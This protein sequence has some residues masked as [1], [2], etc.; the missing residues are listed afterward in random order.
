M[1][2]CPS[3]GWERSA[4]GLCPDCLYS[5]NPA[6]GSDVFGVPLRIACTIIA[7]T[8][9]QVVTLQIIAKQRG[10]RYAL[11]TAHGWQSPADWR[12]R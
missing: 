10:V 8:P 4:S 9:W 7:A 12:I 2:R 3:H 5:T 11:D 1:A 6:T